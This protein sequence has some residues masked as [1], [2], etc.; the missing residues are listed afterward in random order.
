LQ[1]LEQGFKVVVGS[2]NLAAAKELCESAKKDS[3]NP[4]LDIHPAKCDVETDHTELESLVKD[5]DFVVSLL[6]YIYHVQVAKE[7]I[8]YKKHFFTTSYVSDG[9]KKLEEEAL[10]AGIVMI[11]ECGV[12]PGTDHMSA[13][14][15]IDKVHH[16]GGKIESF[17][18]Y[19]GGL[20]APQHNDNPYG[21][22]LSWAPRGVLLASRNDALFLENGKDVKIDGKVLFD[23]YKIFKI[24]GLGEF[25]GYPNRNSKQYI[26]IYTIPEVQTIVRGTFRNR[27]WCATIKK[28]ADLG[29]LSIDN[30]D[31]GEMTYAQLMAKILGTSENLKAECAKKLGLDVTDPILH[32]MEWIGVFSDEKIPAKTPTKLDALCH[33]FKSK[34]VYKDG[35]QDL[36]LMQHYFIADFD[37]RKEHITSTLV[38]YGISHGDTS[39]SRTVSLPVAIAVKLVAQ[40]KFT[41]IGLQVPMIKELYNPILEELESMG[42]KFVEK[43]VKTETK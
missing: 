24:E 5:S 11:N 9:M 37:N 6:P 25:E 16:D 38:D 12:D 32:R 43:V 29:Y 18:S 22:K 33:L 26:D 21:Y 35:E 36:L 3:K 30:E 4:D 40:G 8:K 7:A 17:T 1:N 14:K 13:M 31:F 20:P 10:S 28:Y 27:G 34:L 19:C 41:K 15:I 42:I 2:R 23:N 39:M